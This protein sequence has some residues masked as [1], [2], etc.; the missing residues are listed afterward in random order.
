MLT[1]VW[2]C[3]KE[4]ARPRGAERVKGER[5]LLAASDFDAVDRVLVVRI[6]VA[7]RRRR[8]MGQ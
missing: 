8:E 2:V 6:S 3:R 5:Q 7:L 4:R 1:S